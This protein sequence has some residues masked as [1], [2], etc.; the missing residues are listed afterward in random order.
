M[1]HFCAKYLQNNILKT[2]CKIND[3]FGKVVCQGNNNDLNMTIIMF[4]LV[5]KY[6]KYVKGCLLH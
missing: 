5:L 3:G 2:F 4:T 1:K 6:V